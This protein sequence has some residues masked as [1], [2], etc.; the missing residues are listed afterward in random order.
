M[1]WGGSQSA[2]QG[3]IRPNFGMD[4]AVKF[5]FLEKKNASISLNVNDILRTREYD[6]FAESAFF[7]QNVSRIRDQQIVRL[8]FSWRFGKFDAALFKRKNM[9]GERESMQGAN[10]GMNF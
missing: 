2:A 1:M 4:M 6:S 3:F 8:N 7:V 10:E 5:D 9:R